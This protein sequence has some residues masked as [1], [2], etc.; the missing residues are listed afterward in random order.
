MIDG[1]KSNDNRRL[2][3][4]IL[5]EALPFWP[6]ITTIF[7]LDL[8]S[9]PLLLLTPLPLKIAVDS[10]LGSHPLPG[11]LAAVTPAPLAT[12]FWGLL[13]LAVL[14][15][16]LV[17]LLTQ[18][19]ELASYVV[20]VR[21]GEAMTLG[22]RARIFRHVQRLS[23]AFHDSRGVADSIYRLEVDAPSLQY[24]IVYGVL[25]AIAAAVAI[26]TTIYV[27][28]LIDWQ[29]ALV[30]IA[31]SPLLIY[32]SVA[33]DERMRP[34]YRQVKRLESGALKVI[35]EVL[36]AVRVVKA[37]GREERETQR[38][39]GQSRE[40]VRSRIRLALAEGVY[41]IL[42]NLVTAVGTAAVL[43][44]G[45]VH[46]RSGSLTLGS[47]LLVITYLAQLY[48]PLKQVTSEV[49]GMQGS[50]ASVE[51]AFELLREVP[52]V[53]ETPS[54]RP[55]VRARGAIEFRHV[56]FAYE[57]EQVLRDV[58]FAIAAGTRLG[59]GGKTGA[60]KT[61]LTSLLIR[62]Y[63]PTE[64]TIHLDGVDL[65]EYRLADLRSQFAL[66]L[67]DS[68]LFST[69]IAENIRYGRPDANDR[70]VRAAALAANAINFID[71]LP[72]GY[73]TLVGERGMRLSGGERQRIALA[74][75]FLKDAPILVL[76]E[77]TS[78]VDVGTEAGIMEAMERL[79]NGRT[80]IM[81]AHR[82]GT[83]DV[84][85]E[86]IELE[87]GRILDIVRNEAPRRYLREA[88]L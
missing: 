22:F 16:V 7:I 69:S 17:V 64:G 13:G 43:L 32:L 10:V 44:I 38:F 58:S 77:P 30:A 24:L 74:R 52:E 31:V 66:V 71:D 2:A 76:D 80:T 8:L 26:V 87:G 61:T 88:I 12:S 4:R 37:F 51:R 18:V 84:C 56:G 68:V 25:P 27:I 19:Q 86:A 60:G 49:A 40:G 36:G 15:Q 35:Q 65:R 55:L 83:L 79:M 72:Q 78:S 9:T 5:A 57:G 1:R 39:I 45:I 47:L 73:D 14:L 48:S 33:Y 54:A 21:T 23:L 46:V 67:Q 62:F 82:L 3:R 81:I 6:A 50:L 28:V 34:R 70:Q 11:L 63:D 42:V 29:L 53:P 75:A 41:G 20:S 59:I 85:D